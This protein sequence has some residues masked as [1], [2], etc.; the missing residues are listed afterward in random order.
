[1]KPSYLAGALI[2]FA[3]L[4][5]GLAIGFIWGTSYIISIHAQQVQVT[6]RPTL[7]AEQQYEDIAPN[8]GLESIAA[9]I[10]WD[11]A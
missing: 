8:I 10:Y 11:T 7:V 5:I 2:N 3:T 9:N 1:M 6:G 4:T